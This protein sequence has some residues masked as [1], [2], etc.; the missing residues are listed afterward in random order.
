MVKNERA[1]LPLVEQF[2]PLEQRHRELLRVVFDRIGR[3]VI[4]KLTPGARRAERVLNYTSTRVL[5]AAASDE[6]FERNLRKLK[7]EERSL[8]A[9][10]ADLN[11]DS[12]RVQDS[13]IANAVRFGQIEFGSGAV[14]ESDVVSAVQRAFTINKFPWIDDRANIT[15][16]DVRLTKA[17]FEQIELVHIT[18]GKVI[19]NPDLNIESDEGKRRPTVILVDGEDVRSH[20]QEAI[21]LERDMVSEHSNG[22]PF[23]IVLKKE[24]GVIVIHLICNHKYMDGVPAAY[25]VRRIRDELRLKECSLVGMNPLLLQSALIEADQRETIKDSKSHKVKSTALGSTLTRELVGL[26]E[27]VQRGLHGMTLSFETFIQLFLLSNNVDGNDIRG[28]TLKFSRRESEQLEL[29]GLGNV[30]ALFSALLCGGDLETFK[31]SEFAD[32]LVTE[33]KTAEK[34]GPFIGLFRKGKDIIKPLIGPVVRGLPQE[35][36]SIVNDFS[37]RTHAADAASGQVMVS[38]IPAKLEFEK[39]D[40]NIEVVELG[41]GLGGPACTEYQ[42]AAYTISLVKDEGG[43]IVNI[44]I[45][46][47]YANEEEPNE[48]Q[49]SL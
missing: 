23:V 25:Y 35:L 7:E 19:S 34:I 39:K 13:N 15:R 24:G 47:K 29:Y 17:D 12:D 40:G 36:W 43:K 48:P 4:R 11:L 1:S 9:L 45:R 2:S 44:L 20:T 30:R 18:N 16:D 8:W 5:Q 41:Y 3:P 22:K 21:D 28:S 14:I 49:V 42:L 31:K 46:R 37:K 32:F 33:G 27:E 38:A 6:R 10:Y 26:Y